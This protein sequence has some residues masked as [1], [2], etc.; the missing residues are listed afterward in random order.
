MPFADFRGWLLSFHSFW[1]VD[2]IGGNFLFGRGQ[3]NIW[4]LL[5]SSLWVWLVPEKEKERQRKECFFTFLIHSGISGMLP[6]HPSLCVVGLFLQYI[7]LKQ[8][9]DVYLVPT[10]T[11][12]T[13]GY[14]HGGISGNTVVGIPGERETTFA[15]HL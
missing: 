15:S 14:T 5:P 10:G 13:H 2:V 9:L 8:K 6:L 4:F 7:K 1:T 3:L 12:D 11:P